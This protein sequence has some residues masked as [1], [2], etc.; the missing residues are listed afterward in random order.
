VTLT[1]NGD[2]GAGAMGVAANQSRLGFNRARGQQGNQT[3][4]ILR[5]TVT[6][7]D[8]AAGIQ[9]SR[10][11]VTGLSSLPVLVGDFGEDYAKKLGET[12]VDGR[13]VFEFAPTESAQYVLDSDFIS[14]DSARWKPVR[15]VTDTDYETCVAICEREE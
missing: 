8:A 9:G 10:T 3:A 7:R 11:Q 14:W 6:G 5:Y 4:S 1:S 2:L 13:K 12:W 15:I